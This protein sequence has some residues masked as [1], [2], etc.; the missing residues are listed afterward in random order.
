MAS[1]V[2]GERDYFTDHS[3]LLDPYEYFREM[4]AKG[5]VHQL[6]DRDILIVTG[7]DEA[8]EVL[9]NT[10]DFSSL[11]S[12]PGAAYPLPFEPRGDDIDAQI[13][14]HRGEMLGGDMM[15]TLD[16]QA[17]SARRSLLN[18][19]FVPS[20]LKAN[21]AYMEELSNSIVTD[22]TAK[23]G[24]ELINEVATPY[25]TLVIADLLG[26]P[27]ADRDLFREAIDAAPPPGNMDDEDKPVQFGTLEYMGRFFYGYLSERRAN[28]GDD[29]LS[30]MATSTFP[31]GSTPDLS[32]VVALATFLFAAGQDTSA[33]L[34]GNA[35]RFLA[36]L[37]DLQQ[38]LRSDPS[39]VPDFIEEV[40]RLEGSTKS[41]FRLARRRTRIGDVEV[42]AGKPIIVALAAANRD[43]R[44]WEDPDTL[45]LGRPRIREH[46]AFGRGPHVCA[47]APLARAEVRVLLDK[48]LAHTSE[49]GLNEAMHGP[50]G[51][52][53]FDY[54]PSFMIRGLAELHITLK[55]R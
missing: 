3:V 54:E 36:E 6:E 9:K 24:C 25:V 31:D 37:P 45:K 29:I 5:P 14:A 21:E 12:V 33:K 38:H 11:L 19:L 41:T 2:Q 52:R 4:F 50:T 42:P 13:D 1:T 28:P 30:E 7:F 40:L 43:P 20:R 46:L 55:P 18:R 8:L 49:I 35:L 47:G 39:Q 32:E 34:L 26:V 44:R 48:F 16:G 17:H 51:A 22:M 10:D 23:G 53:R 27:A 15:I